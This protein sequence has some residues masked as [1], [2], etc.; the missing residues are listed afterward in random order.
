VFPGVVVAEE[1]DGLGDMGSGDTTAV[2]I[3][4]ILDVFMH[5]SLISDSQIMLFSGKEKTFLFLRLLSL[6]AIFSGFVNYM[7][8]D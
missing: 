5:T 3:Q 7:M 2:D 1:V 6:C 4:I 8:V